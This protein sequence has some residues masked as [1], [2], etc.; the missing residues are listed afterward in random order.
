MSA[1]RQ[2]VTA[3]RELKAVS[4]V[5]HEWSAIENEDFSTVQAARSA[6]DAKLRASSANGIG[7]DGA[8]LTLQGCLFATTPA[9]TVTPRRATLFEKVTMRPS[10]RHRRVQV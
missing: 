5:E 3:G 1:R 8:V 7:A 9:A 10:E 2:R 4:V 6:K